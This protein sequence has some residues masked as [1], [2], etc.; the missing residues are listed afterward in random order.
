MDFSRKL[1][2]SN[3]K[4]DLSYNTI[5][6][7]LKSYLKISL[8][9]HFNLYSNNDKDNLNKYKNNKY[10]DYIIKIE[11]LKN[12]IIDLS[13][14]ICGKYLELYN[15]IFLDIIK[16]HQELI[17]NNRNII[18]DITL[19]NESDKTKLYY[20]RKNDISEIIYLNIS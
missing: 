1:R 18:N 9:R 5:N 13:H 7:I 11:I 15:E 8:F 4:M 3:I 2:L 19:L 10:I 12:K 16:E 17:D 14:D 6:K 20:K